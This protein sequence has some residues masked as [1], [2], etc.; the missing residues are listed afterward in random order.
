[1]FTDFLSDNEIKRHYLSA[2]IILGQLSSHKR[3]N[4]TIPHKF[5]EA[6]YLGIPYVTSNSSPMIEFESSKCVKLF[7]GGD[8][9]DLIKTICSLVDNSQE[10]KSLSYNINNLYKTSFNQKL[11]SGVFLRYIN[12]YK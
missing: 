11:L 3:T 12:K 7:K 8:E 1:M 2:S 9:I 10:M 4:W 5:Y 6:A